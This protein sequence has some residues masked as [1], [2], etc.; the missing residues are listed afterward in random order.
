MSRAGRGII[1]LHDTGPH[2]TEGLTLDG[3]EQ[4]HN[5]AAE[6][7]G[8]GFVFIQFCCHRRN[9]FTSDGKGL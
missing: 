5:S 1:T 7:S 8:M 2:I 3:T 9:P 4:G 6:I